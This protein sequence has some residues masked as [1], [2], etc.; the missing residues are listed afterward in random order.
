MLVLTRKVD[1]TIILE[2]ESAYW[3]HS[4]KI[5]FKIL[6]IEGRDRVRVGIEAPKGIKILRGE[7]WERSSQ[8]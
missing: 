4:E 8:E 5:T 1:Q 6:G 3:T 2:E 7:L